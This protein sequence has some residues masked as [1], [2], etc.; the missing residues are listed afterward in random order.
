MN[1]I[2]E[3]ILSGLKPFNYEFIDSKDLRAFY[4]D[5]ECFEENNDEPLAD[6][7]EIMIIVEKNGCLT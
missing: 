7:N 6:F 3:R 5:S 4:V 2:R 1:V